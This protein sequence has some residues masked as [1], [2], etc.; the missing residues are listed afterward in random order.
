MSFDEILEQSPKLTEDEKRRLWNMLDQELA[1][2]AEESPE[3]LG[4][5]GAHVRALG[6][7]ANLFA[8]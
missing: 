6:H 3:F 1:D 8:R 2:E 4:E 5:L 7:G